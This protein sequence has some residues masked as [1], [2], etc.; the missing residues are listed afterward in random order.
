MS[1]DK[2]EDYGDRGAVV[3]RPDPPRRGAFALLVRDDVC[4]E[5]KREGGG[6]VR[7]DFRPMTLAE[8]RERLLREKLE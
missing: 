5:V 4:W 7:L 2:P 3:L 6:V 1:N 8:K